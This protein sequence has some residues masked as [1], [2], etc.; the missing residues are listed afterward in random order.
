MTTEVKTIDELMATEVMGFVL[1]EQIN[2]S[3]VG[4]R[5]Y[6]H[7]EGTTMSCKDW[8]PSTDMNQALECAEEF[9][10]QGC[11]WWKLESNPSKG[12]WATV[13]MYED[14]VDSDDYIF[15]AR[16]GDAAYAL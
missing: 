2:I 3:G 11:R 5:D 7:Y 15:S 13:V 12:F 10:K 1:L 9:K 4:P 6:R 14:C 8:S 16:G